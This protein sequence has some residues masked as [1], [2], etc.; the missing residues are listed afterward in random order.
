MKGNVTSSIPGVDAL[1]FQGFQWYA[2]AR[3]LNQSGCGGKNDLFVNSAISVNTVHSITR[4]WC[5]GFLQ[6]MY[7][8]VLFISASG[9]FF[10]GDTVNMDDVNDM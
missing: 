10:G 4:E 8:S 3:F 2:D 6:I 5:G 1:Y 9:F 7:V